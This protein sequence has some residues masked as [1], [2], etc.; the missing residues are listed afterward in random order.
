MAAGIAVGVLLAFTVVS[1]LH[2][3]PDFLAYSNEAFGGPANTWRVRYRLQ[4]R[5]GPGAEVDQ[6]LYGSAPL[7]D[8]WFDY[9]DPLIDPAYYGIHCKPL[10]S[11]MGL[12]FGMV[13]HSVPTTIS[14]TVYISAMEA[15]GLVW[16]P[17]AHNPYRGIIDR[18]PDAE[19][20]NVILVY[21]GQF[22]VTQLAALN[23]AGNATILL[24]M[25]RIPEAL[26]TAQAAFQ[27]APN[28]AMVNASLGG[29]LMASGRFAEG[30]QAMATA[31]HLAQT[32]HPEFQKYLIYMLEAQSHGGGAGH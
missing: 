5:L 6:D 13:P 8:C 11:A 27:L 21:R 19:I 1:S 9:S 7:Q 26:A 24:R 23:D 20:G 12:L 4:R 15:S 14:G 28:S 18:K 31:L 3:Y 17:G 16:G 30:Q 22:D 32:D 10:P 25:H 2:C 29:A